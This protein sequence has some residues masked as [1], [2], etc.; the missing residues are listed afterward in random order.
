MKQTQSYMQYMF[1]TQKSAHI[2]QQQ[3]C[4]KKA[5]YY[6]W[7]STETIN[8]ILHSQERQILE[9]SDIE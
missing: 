6:K 2:Q 3:K 5:S 8:N 9:I 4:H 7:K 1:I